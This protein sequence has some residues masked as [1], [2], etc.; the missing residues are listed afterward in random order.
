[1][2]K[3]QELTAHVDVEVRKSG[4]RIYQLGQAAIDVGFA[5]VPA[6][7][8]AMSIAKESREYSAWLMQKGFA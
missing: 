6:F 5:D 1:M 4:V 7:S 2:G 3:V 8:R